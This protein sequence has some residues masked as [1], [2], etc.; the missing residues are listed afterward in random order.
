MLITRQN[1]LLPILAAMVLLMLVLVL[2]K[3]CVDEGSES[4]LL[5]S[6]PRA[7]APDA[8][9][10]ADTIETLTAN[11]SAMTNELKSLRQANDMRCWSLSSGRSSWSTLRC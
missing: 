10:P 3:S 2:N 9:T 4:V 6:V 8:D 11:V 5:D 1:R 7:G